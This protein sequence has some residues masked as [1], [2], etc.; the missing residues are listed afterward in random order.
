MNKNREKEEE[1]SDKR[2]KNY[3]K[4][5]KYVNQGEMRIK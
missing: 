3:K 2:R 4:E 5:G 1:S